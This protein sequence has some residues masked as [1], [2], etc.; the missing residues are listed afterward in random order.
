MLGVLLLDFSCLFPKPTKAT[1]TKKTFWLERRIYLELPA[2][3]NLN[4]TAQLL[5]SFFG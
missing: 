5:P 1:T 3:L 4:W 2:H